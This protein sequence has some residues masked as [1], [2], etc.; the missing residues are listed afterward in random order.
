MK[1]PMM[2]KE[3]A[4]GEMAPKAPKAP[5]KPKKKKIKS[6]AD[7]KEAAKNFKG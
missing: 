5:M 2:D 4:E 3:M 1:K 6:I 7:L